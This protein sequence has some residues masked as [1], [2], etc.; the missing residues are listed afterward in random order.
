MVFSAKGNQ[1]GMVGGERGILN[2]NFNNHV[3][4]AVLIA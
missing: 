3:L 1:P 4:M 2:R